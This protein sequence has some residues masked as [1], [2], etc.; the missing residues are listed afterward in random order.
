[1][2]ERGVVQPVI[3]RSLATRGLRER[4]GFWE[5]WREGWKGR[6]GNERGEGG[7][8]GVGVL[9]PLFQG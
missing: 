9:E 3:E 7:V 4:D 8:E 2:M 1:M 5:G 6:G